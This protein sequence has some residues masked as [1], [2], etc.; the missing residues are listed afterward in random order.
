MN[1]ESA[2]RLLL[3]PLPLASNR[4]VSPASRPRQLELLHHV[5]T[6]ACDICGT[7]AWTTCHVTL[8]YEHWDCWP[9]RLID[10]LIGIQSSPLDLEEKESHAR[11]YHSLAETPA[12]IKSR[13]NVSS[14]RF[15][16]RAAEIQL[17]HSRVRH[18]SQTENTVEETKHFHKKPLHSIKKMICSLRWKK[19]DEVA[20]RRRR[21][22][23]CSCSDG[24]LC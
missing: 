19:D 21:R 14:G 10:F 12:S 23:G 1:N 22:R 5:S 8:E 7:W 9:S 11:Q 6:T 3:L 4:V 17:P 20:Q 24:A 13:G 18:T 2:C 16:N 15:S